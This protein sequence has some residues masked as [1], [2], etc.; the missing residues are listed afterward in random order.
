MDRGWLSEGVFEA[1]RERIERK[2]PVAQA[3]RDELM[4][5]ADAALTEP[6]VH[7]R[8]AS[9]SP[10]FRQDGT[11]IPN[12]DGVHNPKSDRRCGQLAHRFSDTVYDLAVAYRLT[13][14]ARYADR[15]LAWIHTWC[16]NENTRMF[17]T[18]RVVDMATPGLPYGGDVVLFS[19]FI[20]A[21]HAFALLNGY[22]GWGLSQ[23]AAVR[24][25][26]RQ[27]IEPQRRRMFFDGDE[28][29]NN[30]EDARLAYVG[31]GAAALD[32][33]DLLLEVFER[34]KDIVPLKMTDEGQLPRE[35]MRTRSMHY[36]LAA[37]RLMLIVAELG[38]GYGLGL[39]DYSV[40]GRS[41]RRAVDYAAKY[42]LDM[43]AWPF[44]MIEPL[45]ANGQPSAPRVVFEMAYRHWRDPKYRQVILAWGGRPVADYHATLL[46]ADQ[47]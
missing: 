34:W 3:A 36:T 28:M 12:R 46:F 13:R 31:F 9:G 5:R 11:Y 40:N 21:F 42:L 19:G 23:R 14:D 16:I 25:W 37:L 33:A 38:E 18:G 7:I 39:Y 45:D 47:D 1:A 6:P 41:L 4:R 27:M 10:E 30:W 15:A 2:W 32:D 29:T 24:R 35:T 26:V 20:R 17:S 43:S 44:E 22:A 8:M